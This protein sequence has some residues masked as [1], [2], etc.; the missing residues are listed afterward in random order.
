MNNP[1]KV[2]TPPATL[3]FT[4]RPTGVY[5]YHFKY[6]IVALGLMHIIN[7][8]LFALLIPEYALLVA[9]WPVLAT[10]IVIWRVHD[11]KTKY[12]TLN[13]DSIEI[14]NGKSHFTIPF[15]KLDKV[16]RGIMGAGAT[17][18]SAIQ[19][20]STEMQVSYRPSAL[21]WLH[22]DLHALYAGIPEQYRDD[23]SDVRAYMQ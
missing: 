6:W 16:K 22:K 13:A 12:I 1:Q 3:P 15:T 17:P 18:Y 4:M 20:T 5:G 2:G 21:L 14:K 11:Y 10:P 23:A 7:V 9:F 19:I 8:T